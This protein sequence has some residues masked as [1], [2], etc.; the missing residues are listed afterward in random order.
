M[1]IDYSSL[2]FPKGTPRR[3]AKARKDRAE[4][5]VKKSV[6]AQCVERDGFCRYPVDVSHDTTE[7]FLAMTSCHGP[8]EWAHLHA[9]RRS[10]TRGEAPEKRHTTAGSLMLCRFHHRAYDAHRLFITA[11]T[12]RG[13]DGPLKF[14]RAK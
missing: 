4:V 9:R 1:S 2:T 10:Q 13:A 7:W 14:R 12:R 8:L 3:L 5:K 6:R 11:L